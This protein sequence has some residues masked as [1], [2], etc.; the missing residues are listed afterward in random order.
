MTRAVS[1][2]FGSISHLARP[3]RLTRRAFGSGGRMAGTPAVTF[4]P[5][6]SYAPRMRMNVSRGCGMSAMTSDAG[7]A[8]SNSVFFLFSSSIC[9][10]SGSNFGLVLAQTRCRK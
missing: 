4:S 3:R 6:L 8:P 5:G 7:I 2:C 10:R 9:W 1:G